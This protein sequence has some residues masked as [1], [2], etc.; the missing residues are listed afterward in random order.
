MF[1]AV[2]EMFDNAEQTNEY[3]IKECH[4]GVLERSWTFLIHFKSDP[5]QIHKPC[6]TD[7]SVNGSWCFYFA[8]INEISHN[9]KKMHLVVKM[10]KEMSKSD[11]WKGSSASIWWPINKC[12]SLR[13][14]RKQYTCST[15]KDQS[16][17]KITL[18]RQELMS[19]WVP[20][21]F[22]IL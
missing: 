3:V 1:S 21:S 14:L 20:K 18:N 7:L 16:D 19:C 12:C 17:L 6:L 11:G 10:H 2:L 15:V 13:A 9:A 4:E 22:W 8:Y 5:W